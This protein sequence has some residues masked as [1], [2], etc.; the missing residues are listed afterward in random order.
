MKQNLKEKNVYT[1]T[2][3]KSKLQLIKFEV[4]II[5]DGE[6][7]S[8]EGI[9]QLFMNFNTLDEHKKKNLR[10]TGLGLSICKQII[11]NMGGRVNV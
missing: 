11:E 1:E 8:Q 2:N 10:G 5:D 9:K 3:T 4:K 7:I 6:G